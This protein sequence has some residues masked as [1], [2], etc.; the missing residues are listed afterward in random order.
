M[1]ENFAEKSFSPF[2]FMRNTNIRMHECKKSNALKMR[3]AMLLLILSIF[4]I[5][6][7][8]HSI[9]R[10][11]QFYAPMQIF[12]N[13]VKRQTIIKKQTNV[14]MDF[15]KESVLYDNIDFFFFT[16]FDFNY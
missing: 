11:L 6:F 9:L 5:S 16:F 10:Y 14:S 1:N 3:L 8:K 12:K 13:R 2:L 15:L 7:L 4:Q